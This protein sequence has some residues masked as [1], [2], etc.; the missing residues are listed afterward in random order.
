M[1]IHVKNGSIDTSISRRGF[2]SG[3]AGLTFAFTLGGLGRGGEALGAMQA[4]KFNAWVS[5]GADDVQ[6]RMAKRR[7]CEIAHQQVE[8]ADEENQCQQPCR[9]TDEIFRG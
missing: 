5:I 1:T 3:A 4:T 2:V 7:E 8:A 9:Q 6:R